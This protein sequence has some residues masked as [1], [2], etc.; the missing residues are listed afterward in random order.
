MADGAFAKGVR[1]AIFTN[2]E[3]NEIVEQFKWVGEQVTQS[4]R[5]FKNKEED[6]KEAIFAII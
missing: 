1:G 2:F 4:I 5:R 6:A 3:Y